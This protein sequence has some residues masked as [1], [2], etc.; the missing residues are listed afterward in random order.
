MRFLQAIAALLFILLQGTEATIPR[1][2]KT[3][4]AVVYS[5]A[6][7]KWHH[8]ADRPATRISE[9]CSDCVM[10]DGWI[11][12]PRHGSVI[13]CYCLDSENWYHTAYLWLD[14]NIGNDNGQL[15]WNSSKYFE[16][17]D[18]Q[19]ILDNHILQATC[20]RSDGTRPLTK[21][22]LEAYI[23]VNQDGEF[24]VIPWAGR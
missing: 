12:D 24:F 20:A 7:D 3:S 11:P 18:N 21:L 1:R 23:E 17:C 9:T 2:P 6:G 13:Q 8:G 15:I 14:R 19:E 10:T 4:P 5:P 16:T 22:D